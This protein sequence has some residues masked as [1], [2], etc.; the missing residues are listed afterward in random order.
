MAAYEKKGRSDAEI[1]VETIKGP[2]LLL[3]GEEDEIWPSSTMANRIMERLKEN[4]FAYDI[5]H[6]SYTKAGHLFIQPYLPAVHPYDVGDSFGGKTMDN[7]ICG[8]KAWKETL[9][10]LTA[11]FP[12]ARMT[13]ETIPFQLVKN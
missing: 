5:K 8:E 4:S 13:T 10:F 6:L 9:A 3:S 1:P 7:A 2:V 12:P 11:H